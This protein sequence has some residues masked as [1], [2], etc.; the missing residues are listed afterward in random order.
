MDHQQSIVCFGEVLWDILPHV[1]LP[2][3]APM[4][5]AYHLKQNGFHPTM[6][7]RIGKDEYGDK[8]VQL[9]KEK[10]LETDYVQ[11]DDNYA[12]GLVY[13]HPNE[14][15]EVTYNIVYPSAW[16][17]IQWKDEFEPLM[18]NTDVLVFGSLA[19][20][21]Q[22]SR[23]TLLKLMEKATF[24]V[25]DINLRPPHYTQEGVESLLQKADIL[26]LNEAEL[27]L[28]SGWYQPFENDEK[29]IEVIQKKFNLNTVI[30]TKGGD[31]AMIKH[32]NLL[33][34]HSGYKVNVADTI[35]SGDAFLAGFLSQFLN[36]KPVPEALSYAC[37]LGA[38]IASYSGACPNYQL[39]E[40]SN[41]IG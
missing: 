15:N 4:N 3:G 38:L 41:L 10:N 17:F 6:I 36:G 31:G 37:G 13:A 27:Q 34:S 2:G 35:G 33:Y 32:N 18:E 8:L 39:S 14:Q 21:N 25:L 16:D 5:V 19:S 9:F 11:V 22:T 29:A 1:S 30:V 20:R 23:E 12:T 26:K 24:K 7:T 28:I 40:V